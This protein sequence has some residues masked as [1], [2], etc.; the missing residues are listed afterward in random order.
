MQVRRGPLQKKKDEALIS[1]W[2]RKVLR[3][4][5]GLVNEINVWGIRSNHE[6]RCMYQDLDFVTTVRKSRLKWLG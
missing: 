1:T 6:L 5:F 3:K 4:I 2:E